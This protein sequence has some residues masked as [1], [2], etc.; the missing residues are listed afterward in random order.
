MPISFQ[1]IISQ[2]LQGKDPLAEVF[3]DAPIKIA[4]KNIYS[5][6]Y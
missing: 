6:G 3:V 4:P 5:G 2:A 1:E